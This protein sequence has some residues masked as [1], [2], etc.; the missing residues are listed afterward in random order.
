MSAVDIRLGVEAVSPDGLITLF[1]GDADVPI[2]TVPSPML[3]MAG[4]H[5]GIIYHPGMGVRLL[6][7]PYM[8]GEAFAADW[9]GQRLARSCSGVSGTGSKA[10][11]DQSQAIDTTYQQYGITTS[12]PAG[13]ASFACKLGAMPASG[14]VFAATE[15]EQNRA[16]SLWDVKLLAG[17]IAAQQAA[18][19]ASRPALP[20]G[21]RLCHR[22]GLAGPAE[23][24]G[25]PVQ[26]DRR[27]DQSHR[28]QRHH[29]ERPAVSRPT[30]CDLRGRPGALQRHRRRHRA[31]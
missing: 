17:F 14:Y 10:R 25:G 30:R 8:T 19:G 16:S 13:E 4:L 31:L 1:Y 22:P 27:P 2:F 5:P 21:R 26:P 23:Q 18:A 24:S 3:E 29:R 12:I 15:F 6:I 11:P 7:M 20:Y 9:G 28:L